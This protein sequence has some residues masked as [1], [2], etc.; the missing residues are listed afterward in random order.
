[1]EYPVGLDSDAQEV[2][3][4]YMPR[5]FIVNAICLKYVQEKYERQSIV[6]QGPVYRRG[7]S[8]IRNT[9]CRSTCAAK[10]ASA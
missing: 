2:K 8:S 6:F 10:G 3:E 9:L 1:M 7:M 4:A 5:E